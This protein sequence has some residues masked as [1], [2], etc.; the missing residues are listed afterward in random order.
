MTKRQPKTLKVTKQSGQI[1]APGGDLGNYLLR[2]VP[3]WGNPQWLSA[4]TWRAFVHRQPVASLCRDSIIAYLLSLDWKILPRDSE[5][6]DEYKEEVRHYTRLFERGNAYYTDI[7]FSSHLEWIVKDLL[8][9]PFGGASELGR[10]SD[11]PDGKVLWIRPLDGG[12]LAPTLDANYPIVQTFPNYPMVSFPREFISRIYLSPRTEIRREGWGMAPPEKIYLALE[13]LNRGDSYYAQLLLNTPELGILDLKDMT[14]QSATEWVKSFRDLLYGI[15]P[16]KI[17]VLYEHEEAAEWIPFGKLP[18]EILYDSVIGRYITIVTAGYGIS[19]SDI[20]F[21]SSNN[22]G[23][24]LAGTIRQERRSARGGKAVVKAKV[25]AY[26]DQILPEHL[27]FKWI[28][29]DD[30]RVLALSRARLATA[31]AFQTLVDL[32]AFT[33]DEARSQAIVDGLFTITLPER[34]NRSEVE[35]PSNT[36]RYIG[37]NGGEVPKPPSSGGQGDILARQVITRNRSKIEVSLAKAIHSS[38]SHLG[39]LVYSI[40]NRNNDGNL[41]TEWEKNFDAAVIGK[42]KIDPAIESIID[43]AFNDILAILDDEEW[44]DSV[45]NWVANSINQEVENRINAIKRAEAQYQAEQ[46]FIEGKSDEL[47]IAQPSKFSI[48]PVSPLTVKKTLLE[49]LI[50]KMLLIS[51]SMYLDYKYPLDI[52]DATDHNNM[53]ITREVADRVY[54]TLPSIVQEVYDKIMTGD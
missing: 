23:E 44:V 13:M 19:P 35:W 2:N 32:R 24:T 1:S 9:L 17:P 38:N 14:K 3:V 29:F 51:K 39:P 10:E 42:S 49:N 8:D 37:K 53:K 11:T 5:K 52:R 28:D 33:P 47:V 43:S 34:I 7:D 15:N 27:Q 26:F 46:D 45:S 31:Q 36:L 12:T 25:K 4:D 22:G 16:L 41:I 6:Q 40:R 50:P 18:N 54:Q 20:G 21:S 48:S 30:E